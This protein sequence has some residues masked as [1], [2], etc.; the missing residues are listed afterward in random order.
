MSLDELIEFYETEIADEMYHAGMSPAT[1]RPSYEWLADHGYSGIAYTLREHHDLTLKQFIVEE[2]GVDAGVDDG[3]PGYEWGINDEE[4]I[5]RFETYLR[6]RQRRQNLADS[7]IRSKRTRLA[8]YAREYE[9][10]HGEAPLV[11]RVGDRDLQPEEIERVL[12]VFDVLD[13]ELASNDSK[14]KHHYDVKDWYVWLQNRA[15]GTYNPAATVATSFG[16]WDTDTESGETKPALRPD[17][18]REILA[19]CDDRADRLLVVA[20][21]AWGLRRGE[22]AALHVSQFIPN[23]EPPRLE[24]EDRKNGPSSVQLLYG[25]DEYLDRVE[26]LDATGWNGYLFPSNAAESGHVAPGTVNNRFERLVETAGVTLH[27]ERPTPHAC[28]RF[29]Y[30]AYQ[31]AMQDLQEQVAP[32]AADQGSSSAAVVV[33]KYLSEE[34]VRRARRDAMRERLADVFEGKL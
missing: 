23:A 11:D 9:A 7:T 19:V 18:L 14:A 31:D 8:R 26:A 12:S 27:G 15:I 24:F 5:E 10:L 3:T 32:M 34:Q 33:D 6:D 29:W 30:N 21:G 1:K 13:H 20:L 2:V 22:V 25:V 16:G 4:T 28:R 17:Q